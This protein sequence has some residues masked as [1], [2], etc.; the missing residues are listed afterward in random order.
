MS[1]IPK[2][3]MLTVGYHGGGFDGRFLYLA[4]RR[5]GASR[6]G[7]YGR[8]LYCGTLGVNGS[9]CLRASDYGQDGGLCAVGPGPSPLV[10]T[11]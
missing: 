9:L 8:S 5:D 6:G 4:P 10:N 2:C 11:E 3:E 7:M 1:N